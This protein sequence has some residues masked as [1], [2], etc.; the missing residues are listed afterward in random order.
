MQ[1]VILRLA[2]RL[3]AGAC[4]VLGVVALYAASGAAARLP[5]SVAE[6]DGCTVIGAGSQATADGSVITSQS[7]SCSECRLHVVPGRAFPRGSKAPVHW[8]MIYY[9]R[10]DARGGRALGDYGKVIGEIPQVEHT[11]TYFHTGYSYI[12]ERQLAIAESTCSQ[13][14]ELDVP[15]IEDVTEQI[16]TVEQA[17]VFALERAATSRDALRVIT[18]LMEEYGFLP[19]TD[20]SEALC[21]AD[22][23]E[24]WVLELFSVGTEWKRGSGKPGVIWAARRLPDGHVT[25]I[26]NYVRIREI[27]LRD[28]NTLAS[29]NYKQEAID[30]GWYDPASDAPFIWQEAYAPPITEG[31]LNRLWLVYSSLAPNLKAWPN[32]H[33]GGT[34]GS[35]TMAHQPIEGASFYPFSFKPE[36]KVSVRDVIAF[37]RSAF[38]GTVYDTT[39]DPAWLVPDGQGGAK[40]SVLTTPFPSSDLMDLLRIANHR[41]VAR[42]GYGMVAQLRNSLPDPVGGV[43]WFYVD[44]PYVSTYVPVYA[45]V[46]STSDLYQTYD[47]RQFSEGSARW[48]V[49]FVDNLLHLKWQWAVKDLLAVRDPLE[50]EFFDQQ[51]AVEKRAA[52]LYRQDPAAAAAYLTDLTRERMERVVKMYRDLR[53]ALITKYTNSLYLIRMLGHVVAVVGARTPPRR[54]TGVGGSSRSAPPRQE[55][56]GHNDVR[57]HAHHPVARIVAR[58][59]RHGAARLGARPQTDPGGWTVGPDGPQHAELRDR[60]GRRAVG[61]LGLG[62][63]EE[64]GVPGVRAGELRPAGVLRGAPA[65]EEGG[66]P[67]RALPA[68]VAESR[69][70]AG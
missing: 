62:T 13:R 55:R 64:P 27:D 29:S 54:Q 46:R 19:S 9:G 12:N 32:R 11:Y 36:R 38:E 42:Y 37:Q 44:N 59:V 48:A 51:P 30:R 58:A 6:A 26:P 21:L 52:E 16:M 70:H 35:N 28:Q 53:A 56:E 17:E 15:Y 67:G 31:S 39:A 3:L 33:L 23:H 45:G 69:C 5:T 68:G 10:D 57:S 7:D 2:R 43:L 61:S 18:S 25:V 50:R 47:A 24:V 14:H 60:R 40:R 63:T 20:G 4:V 49:E 65:A 1:P 22:A 41:P 34:A 8:G 66:N